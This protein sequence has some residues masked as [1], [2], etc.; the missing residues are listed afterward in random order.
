M[1]ARPIPLRCLL[2]HPARRT[3][4]TPRTTTSKSSFSTR[5]SNV[6]AASHENPYDPPTGNLFGIKPGHKYEK[7]GWENA[8]TYGFGGSLLLAAIAYAFKPDT[9]YVFSL[10][11]SSIGS[12]FGGRDEIGML[13]QVWMLT[14]LVL[15]YKR[16]LLKKLGEDLKRK[17]SLRTR[18]RCRRN[19]EVFLLSTRK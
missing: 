19:R 17:E 1:P 7:E 16:G 5:N 4:T 13:S 2:R 12:S 15:G 11:L 9:S 14:V 8:M 18:T 3:T 6:R 10:H